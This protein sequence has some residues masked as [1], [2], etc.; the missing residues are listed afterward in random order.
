MAPLRI[1]VIGA[2][3]IGRA[4]IDA[5]GR[6]EGLGL[7][8]VLTASG[9]HGTADP[10]AFFADPADLYIDAAGPAA[11]RA[12]GRQALERGDLWTVGASALGDPD[13]LRD[14]RAAAAARGTRLRLFSPWI[15]GVPQ[16]AGDP[17]ARLSV[18]M[19]RPGLGLEWSGPLAE[20]LARAPD[21]LNSATAAALAGPGVAATTVTL[22]DSGPGGPHRIEADLLTASGRF[23]SVADFDPAAP[24]PHPTAAALIGALAARL[25]PLG[26]G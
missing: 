16:A 23:R 1:G 26:Y 8:G 2:G 18:T 5:L 25:A 17:S 4:V 6:M 13:L 24:G 14:L 15:A 21:D 12:F 22:R 7:A 9:R 3:R 19:T 11:L 20:A 10:R